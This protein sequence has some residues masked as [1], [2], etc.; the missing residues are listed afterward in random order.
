MKITKKIAAVLLAVSI[1]TSTLTYHASAYNL[2]DAI[3]YAYTYWN[4]RCPHYKSLSSNCANYVSQC[5]VASGRTMTKE[6]R[7]EPSYFTWQLTETF[8]K[9]TTQ[10]AYFEKK[11]WA[12]E[13]GRYYNSKTTPVNYPTTPYIGAGNLIYYDWEGNGSVDHVSFVTGVEHNSGY[14]VA[15]VCQNTSNRYKATWHLYSYMTTAQRQN[16]IY[17]VEKVNY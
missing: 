13:K 3:D 4:Y 10:K 11:K 14:P 6:W 7:N 1:S 17:V 8:T 2:N 5:L 12:F 15:V 9:C 16:C